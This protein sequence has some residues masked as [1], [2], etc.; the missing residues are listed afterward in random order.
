LDNQAIKLN[1]QALASSLL[2][3][4]YEDALLEKYED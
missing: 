4:K 1:K 3:P 2:D